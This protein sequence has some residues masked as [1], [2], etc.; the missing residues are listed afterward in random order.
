M[1]KEPSDSDPGR[2]ARRRILRRAALFTYGFFL[3]A[4]IIAVVGSALVA[5]LLSVTGLPFLETWI[6][7]TVIVL[8]V[9]LIGMGLGA[10]RRNGK[11]LAE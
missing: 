10:I 6:I 1:V 8:L 7:I 9:P 2:K 3:T 11:G 4:V 5:W